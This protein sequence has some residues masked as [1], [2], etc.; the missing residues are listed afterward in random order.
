MWSST[1]TITSAD[2]PLPMATRYTKFRSPVLRVSTF[3]S[4][5]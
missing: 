1:I 3:R 5:R 4:S 2:R